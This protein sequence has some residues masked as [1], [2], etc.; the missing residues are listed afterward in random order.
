MKI[1]L[2]RKAI[3]IMLVF[4]VP[5]FFLSRVIWPDPADAMQ[6]TGGQIPFFIFL[7]VVESLL[8]GF[9]IAFAVT[10]WHKVKQI[11]PAHRAR[12]KAAFFSLIWILI[13]WW[14]HDNIHRANGMDLQGLLYIEYAFHMTIIIASIILTH[15]FLATIK[16]H[17]SQ[18][19]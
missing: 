2:N 8:F 11:N 3:I 16:E 13:Q 10:V 15:Y 12:T 18:S 4:A 9:A 6:P 19:R 17:W 5:A 7:S 14:P 1:L